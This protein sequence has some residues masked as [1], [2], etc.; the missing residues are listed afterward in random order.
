M[1]DRPG[2]LIIPEALQATERYH[3]AALASLFG[4]AGDEAETE[5]DPATR[6]LFLCFTNRCGSNFV[7]E[8]MAAGGR[9][10]R[11]EEVFNGDT[12]ATHVRERGLRSFAAYVNFLC[13]RL[14]EGGRLAAKV[15]L[16]Q[17]LMLTEAGVLDQIV[18]RS[19]FLLLERQDRLRQA[20]SLLVAVQNRQWTSRQASV[21]PDAA[22]VYRRDFIDEQMALIAQQTF[23]F[24]RFFASN[25][26]TPKHLAY[27][28]LIAQPAQSLGAIEDW[29]GLPA[30][31]PRD[32]AL[33]IQRQASALKEAWRARYQ[34]GL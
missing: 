21:K 7:A 10:N 19:D 32:L 27:E 4:A 2:R 29:L 11:A 23:G 1:Q 3:R 30:A 17:L 15:S 8:L 14:R 16:E 13:D 28:E 18:T 26:L 9:I 22:L 6:F 31:G 5:I 20:I 34:A 25:G 24:Y 33:P 12:I